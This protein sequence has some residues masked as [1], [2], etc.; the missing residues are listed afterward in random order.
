VIPTPT[1]ECEPVRESLSAGL[2]LEPG[3]LPADMVTTHLATCAACRA[4][5]EQ[6]HELTR[7]VRLAP[8]R[9]VPDATGSVV[10]AVLADRAS[11]APRHRVLRAAIAGVAAVQLVAVVVPVLVLGA[12][13]PDVPVHAARELAVFNLA[14][15][16]GL[17]AA[18]VRPTLARG[19]LYPVAAASGLLVVLSVADTVA[20]AT[21]L[22]EEL[23]HVVAL[24][25]TLLLIVLTRRL[26]STVRTE[27]P[28]A[29]R[30]AVLTGPSP[31]DA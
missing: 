9:P 2:D 15:A 29:E 28:P 21:T 30:T 5:Q 7:R 18:V 22:I 17:V 31:P 8:A 27:S 19:V 11:R 1:P 24:V 3:Q 6:A 25:G 4:W 12:A 13:G 26:P 20:G 14:L 23:P 10:A 16:L